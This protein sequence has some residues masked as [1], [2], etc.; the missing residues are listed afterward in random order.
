MLNNFQQMISSLQKGGGNSPLNGIINMM[1][2]QNPQL[3]QMMGMMNQM[4]PK[5]AKKQIQQMA[6]QGKINQ[7]QLNQFYSFA[8]QFGVSK[9]TLDKELKDINIKEKTNRW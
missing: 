9:E 6:Q 1:A 8:D 4:S 2:Q 3:K 7:S 5:D